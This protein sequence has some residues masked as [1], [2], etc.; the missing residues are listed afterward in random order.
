[1]DAC[2]IPMTGLLGVMIESRRCL[3]SFTCMCMIVQ[4]GLHQMI[5]AVGNLLLFAWNQGVSMLNLVAR[6]CMSD[7]LSKA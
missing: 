2:R 5:L 4:R 7:P 3:V 1:M 6:I